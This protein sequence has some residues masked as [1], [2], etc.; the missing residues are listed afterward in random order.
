M[1]GEQSSGRGNI[2]YQRRG[3]GAFFPSSK[4]ESPPASTL[5]CDIP[6]PTASQRSPLELFALVPELSPLPEPT[7][8][9]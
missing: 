8:I 1:Q 5:V 4:G 6:A 3:R 7:P 9:F 2:T